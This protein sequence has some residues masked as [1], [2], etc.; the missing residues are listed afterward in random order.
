MTQLD[1]TQIKEVVR[2]RYGELARNSTTATVSDCCST[3]CCSGDETDLD[4]IMPLYTSNQTDGLPME[5]LAASAGCG[6]PHAIGTLQAG[7]TVVDFGSGG[8][9]DCF[10]AAKAV[11]EQ[12]R[13][14]GIDMTEDMINLARGNATRL[15]LNN[16]E[17]HLSEME[18]TPL[19]DDTVDAIISNCVINLA[20]DKDLVFREAYRILRPGGRLMVSDLVKIDEIPQEEAE[21]TANWVSCLA[22]TEMK[23]VYLG[24]MQSAGF[25]DVQIVSSAPW[26]EEGWR[27]NIHS[28]NISAVKPV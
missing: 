10:I 2:E 23:D 18:N 14:V 28:M 6:N 26:N 7:E 25:T 15:G 21:D 24:R 11:G 22:G 19:E 27:S 1:D 20:P 4:S 8:G 13:V 12:G 16:V 3:D 5:A 17:F 9:I